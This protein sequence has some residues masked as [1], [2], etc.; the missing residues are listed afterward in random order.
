[1][2]INIT[3]ILLPVVQSNNIIKVL[4][5]LEAQSFIR[6]HIN[7]DVV[8]LALKYKQKSS[9]N[10]AVCLQLIKLYKKAQKKLPLYWTKLLALD[11]RSYAQCTSELVARYKAT[12]LDGGR[13]LD[14]TA[15]IGVDSLFLANSFAEVTALELNE[16][17]HNI[18]VYNV[19]KLQVKNV[20][21][22]NSDASKY[23]QGDESHYDLIY[24]DPDRRSEFG[25]SV[26]LEHLSPD[27]LELL[28]LLKRRT[29]KVY[30]KLSPLFDIHEVY[31]KFNDVSEIYVIAEKGEIKEV[32]VYLDFSL[33]ESL[34][35]IR[36]VDVATGFDHTINTSEVGASI[37]HCDISLYLHIPFALVAKS[38]A[39]PYFLNGVPHTKHSDFEIYY[40]STTQ[41]DGFRTFSIIDT[42][43]FAQKNISKMLANNGVQQCILV[44]KG[45]NQKPPEW[46]KK[47]K[48]RDGGEFYLFLLK[49][50]S[51]EAIL[52]RLISSVEI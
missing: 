6:R 35:Q 8:S 16:D 24:I 5:N 37:Y 20:K 38:N 19:Q 2:D 48:T 49:G 27:V 4:E 10:M 1:M 36:M 26:A 39:A 29:R 7:D 18:A 40:S 30:I 9:Y 31:R 45:T 12:F 43:S 13:M 23:L 25:R 17:L 42:S 44:I 14:L 41:I 22:V 15:G 50:K 47:L 34:A 32:G 51:P 11:D 52:T 28:P 3:P 33:D 21:R 46:H